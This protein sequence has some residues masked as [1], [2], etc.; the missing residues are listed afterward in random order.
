[1]PAVVPVVRAHVAEVG[2]NVPVEFVEKLTIPVGLVAPDDDVSVTV[3]VHV[4]WL[5]TWTDGGLHETVVVVAWGGADVT[6]R[7]TVVGVVVAPSG[8]PVTMK[9]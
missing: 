1:M 3:A 6:I 9:L 4:V 2:L 5:F 7:L 8:E